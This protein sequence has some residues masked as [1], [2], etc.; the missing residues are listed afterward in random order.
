MRVGVIGNAG[1]VGQSISQTLAKQGHSVIPLCRISLQWISKFAHAGVQLPK[2]HPIRAQLATC[3][4]VVNCAGRTAP[5][6]S[7]KALE[8]TNG[9]LPE[10]LYSLCKEFKMHC[11]VQISSVAA[12]GSASKPGK[13]IS[14][15]ANPTPGSP[16]GRSKLFGDQRLTAAKDLATRLVI[17]RP[18]MLYGS[19]AKG[20]FGLFAKAASRGIPLPI[21]SLKNK[22]SF[23]FIGNLAS[24][25]TA[26]IERNSVAGCYLVTDSEAMTPGEFYDALARAS[27]GRTLTW[28]FPPMLLQPLGR[29][30]LR[31]RF[32]SLFSDAVYD[33]TRFRIE[34]A[35]SPPFM[36]EPAVRKTMHACSSYM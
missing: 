19:G 34:A 10:L 17:L 29:V 28:R 22:R 1:F 35:W 6:N 9:F 31:S 3:D 26:A 25:V 11:F 2:S 30:L 15:D 14:D 33:S 5:Q 8:L 32:E 21:R 16:Y 13:A 7:P 12:V 20:V 24:A 18:P 4:A 36:L 23:V 27:I